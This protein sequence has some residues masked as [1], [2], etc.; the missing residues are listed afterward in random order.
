MTG[1]GIAPFRVPPGA[2][3]RWQISG[4]SDTS[5]DSRV[6]MDTSYVQGWTFWEDLKIILK[7][8]QAVLSR[9]GSY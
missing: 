3:G 6:E 8:P 9:K 4:R 5:Y 1:R 7:T 2:T